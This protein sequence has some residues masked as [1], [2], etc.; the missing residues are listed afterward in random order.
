MF[1]FYYRLTLLRNERQGAE[2][3]LPLRDTCLAVSG[4]HDDIV[5]I[6]HQL[7]YHSLLLRGRDAL[8]DRCPLGL[9][10]VLVLDVVVQDGTAPALPAAQVKSHRRRVQ[11]YEGLLRR[12][13]GS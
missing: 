6:G 1:L 7:P 13:H 4:H 12:R 10:L 3:I 5:T 2:F 9:V 11:C 8:G